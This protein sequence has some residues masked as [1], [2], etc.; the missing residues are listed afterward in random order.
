MFVGVHSWTHDYAYVYKNTDNFLSDFKKL[1][2][3][4]ERRP[5]S[6]PN[7]C[8]FPGGDQQHR[9][10]QVQRRPHNERDRPPGQISWLQV[11]RLERIVG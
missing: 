10:L 3:Y 7:V 1:R 2:D 5:A 4:I 11:L 8:R 6:L 9:V